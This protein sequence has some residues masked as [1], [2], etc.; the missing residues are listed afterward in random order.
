[1]KLA[2][3]MFL[4]TVAF[5]FLAMSCGG[6]GS[7][8]TIT[9]WSHTT[10]PDG[11][12][13]QENIDRFN[14]TDPEF[15]IELQT[16]E[17]GTMF[18]RLATSVMA[19]QGVPDLA[20]I[21]SETLPMFQG[22]GLMVSWDEHIAG[23]SLIRSNYLD[24]AWDLG[25]F[26]GKQYGIPMSMTSWIMYYNKELVD[27]YAPGALDDGIVTYAEVF[28]AG[29]AAKADGI[30]AIGQ[31][32][33]MQNVTNLYMQM[34]GNF[35]E[36]GS[37]T[38]YN[39]TAIATFQTFK[40]LLDRGFMNAQGEDAIALFNSGQVIFLPEGTWMISDMEKIAGFEWGQT[41]TTQWDADNLVQGSGVPHFTLFRSNK[42]SDEKLAGIVKFVEWLQT[43][44]VEWLRS[45]ANPT[46]LN[47]FDNPEFLQM[48]Q[49]FLV[50]NDK[51][52]DSIRVIVDPG[53]S[54]VF[55]QIDSRFWD[56]V[57]GR[58]DIDQ[59]LRE[60]QQLLNDIMAQAQ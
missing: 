12:L 3:K 6:G 24:T 47:M 32:W 38:F 2:K 14:A 11:D 13:I 55:G 54:E 22:Q 42:R 7:G 19:G 40:D 56:M 53:S 31:T 29:D 4:A 16:M 10:G 8:N 30:L 50:T 57:S 58:T 23:T 44:Q 9:L 52:R 34:G 39:D 45:G 25:T 43:N 35:S 21:A 18:N 27:R 41:I 20:M 17:A 48:P 26:E 36:N 46:A 5:G 37:P 60:V 51:F 28:A 59:S 15:T 1:M 49:S 33:P